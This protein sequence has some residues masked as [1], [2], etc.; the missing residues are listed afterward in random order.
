MTQPQHVEFDITKLEEYE[1]ITPRALEIMEDFKK[2]I[3]II[4]EYRTKEIYDGFIR[5]LLKSMTYGF[6]H[7]EFRSHPV[8]YKFKNDPN[9]EVK[10][11]PFRAFIINVM[12][13]R[14]MICLDPEN[15]DESF[16]LSPIDLEKIGPTMI[17]RYFDEKYVTKYNRFIPAK[18]KLHVKEIN[19]EL[20]LI[21]ADSTFFLTRISAMFSKFIGIS[22][23]VETVMDLA[24]RYPEFDELL[25][26][27]ID[28]TQQPAEIEQNAS[29]AMD[30][31]LNIV[32]TDEKFTMLKPLF[33]PKMGLNMNQCRD[34][35][36]SMVLKP[37]ID[38]RTIPEPLNTNFMLTGLDNLTYYYIN[39]IAGRKAQIINNKYMG[40]TGHL[41]I[42]VAIATAEKLSETV[43]DCHSVNPIPYTIKTK[44]H[45]VKM[46]GRR[47]RYP[48]QTEYHILNADKDTHLIGQTLYFRSPITCC[49][50]D[51]VCKE[52]YGE[53]Y[54][55]NID[56]FN[57][58]ILSAT[59]IMNPVMQGILSAKHHQTTNSS[60]IK[61]SDEFDQFFKLSVT[62][63][64]LA[65][66]IEDV[67][68]Y[69]LILR[70]EDISTSD[71]E[72]VELDYTKKRKRRKKV[73]R[74]VEFDGEDE[75]EDDE[76]SGDRL[77]YYVTKFSVAKNLH[78]KHMPTEFIEFSDV[79][80][81][82][83]FLH[84]EFISSMNAD[85]DEN[86]HY[87]YID[88]EDIDPENTIFLVDVQNNELTKP[89]KMIQKVLNNTDHEGCSTYEEL[90]N[91]LL[92]LIIMSKLDAVSVHGEMIIRS[93]VRRNTNVLKRPDFSK[94]VMAGDY[95]LLTITSALKKNP[96]ITTSLSTPYLKAQLISQAETFEK[97]GSSIF[98]SYFRSTLV[99]EY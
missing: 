47:Y 56:N 7:Y 88:F 36:L 16:I 95:Q 24:N 13:W 41:L 3:F 96:S 69:T 65:D 90:A 61:F 9:E 67:Q 81:K 43:E 38:G 55:T 1:T 34:M 27:K 52:C 59:I 12:M 35:M 87:L 4:E 5:S 64:V 80:K 98:D 75:D 92:D 89:M 76:S 50:H 20:N 62:D 83:L 11:L 60:M 29:K 79:D 99:D 30:K 70:Q 39:A 82:E 68:D 8:Q 74:D 53:L 71:G 28:E 94:I 21:F 85:K 78:N 72:E 19:G 63:I 26:Y 45:L 57:T 73:T 93:L 15:L 10:W 58:G 48:G 84:T 40:K 77:N 54:Y 97:T 23:G 37:N 25:H 51:G 31:M 18:P 49:A 17:K 14:P 46:D 86:G 44:D 2:Q 6:E 32:L 42:Q 66:D 22:A 33:Q 91:K